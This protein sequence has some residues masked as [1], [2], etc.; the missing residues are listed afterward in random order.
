MLFVSYFKLHAHRETQTWLLLN[1]II[2]SWT[3][4]DTGWDSGLK[5]SLVSKFL[6]I[7]ILERR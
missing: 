5:F 3:T 7:A 2:I 6:F 1:I 4:K